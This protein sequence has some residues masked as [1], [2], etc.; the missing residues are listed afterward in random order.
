MADKRKSFLQ[1][2]DADIDAYATAPDAP[3]TIAPE[4]L[5]TVVANLHGLLRHAEIV[6]AALEASP[7]APTPAGP[8]EP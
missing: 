7:D 8:F 6:K 2:Q 5:E 4:Y 1:L 3:V